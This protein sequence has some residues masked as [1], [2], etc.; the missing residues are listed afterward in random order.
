MDVLKIKNGSRHHHHPHSQV[1]VSDK[2]GCGGWE[3]AA[4]HGVPTLRFPPPKGEC[5]DVDAAA[6]DAARVLRDDHG[7]RYVALAGYLKV[8]CESAGERRLVFVFAQ[9]TL[10]ID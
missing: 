10:L 3:Y 1:V 5:A 9:K 6:A 8:L 7:V 2:P 4:A